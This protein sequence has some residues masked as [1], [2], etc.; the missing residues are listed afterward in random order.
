MTASRIDL[1]FARLFTE[2]EQAKRKRTRNLLEALGVV[3]LVPASLIVW[4]Y[5]VAALWGWFA[6]PLG[7]PAIGLAHG[8][9]I[10]LLMATAVPHP[11]HDDKKQRLGFQTTASML[12]AGILLGLGWCAHA[13]MT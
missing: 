1:D 3:L 7:A 13:W 5:A 2:F 6:V 9:G 4:G 8:L 12:Y 11:P 10:R